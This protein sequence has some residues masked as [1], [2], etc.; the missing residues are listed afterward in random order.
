ME[1]YVKSTARLYCEMAVLNE[2]EVA[3]MKFQQNQHEESDSKSEVMD[4]DFKKPVL[5]NNNGSY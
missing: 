5:R 4:A 3:T 1:R 2:L